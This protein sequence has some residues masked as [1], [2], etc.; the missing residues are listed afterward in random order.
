MITTERLLLR[1]W[2][3]EDLEPF[4]AM[5]ADPLVMRF[6]PSMLTR[7]QSL[8]GVKRVEAHFERHGWGLFAAEHESEFIGYIGLFH[9]PFQASFTPAVEIGWR[10]AAQYWNR[11]LATEGARA[12]LDFGFSKLGLAEIVA[13]TATSNAP[14]M[15][16]MEKIGMLHDVGGDFDHP[17]V[18]QGHPLRRHVLYRAKRGHLPS[19]ENASRTLPGAPPVNA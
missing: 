11:G 3:P 6:F 14:S 1:R 13:F 4:A 15:R 5:N 7:E 2:K 16:V 12:C 19:I 17:R 9:V 10:L 8:D 18:A